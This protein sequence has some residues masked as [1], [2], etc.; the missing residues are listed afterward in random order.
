MNRRKF[1]KTVAVGAAAI[2]ALNGKAFSMNQKTVR[3]GGPVFEQFDDPTDWV[4]AHRNLG[5]TAAYC[6][7]S[8]DDSNERRQAFAAAAKQANLII[9][10]VGAW[11]NPISPNAQEAKAALEKNI[12]QLELAEEIGANC[13]VNIAGS[14]GPKWDGPHPDNVSDDT[15][16][17]I[18]ETVRKII[19]A[20]KP[21][22][23]FYTLEAMPWVLPDS[24][25][26]Y[27]EL[28]K[29]IDRKVFAVHLDPVNMINS[30][31]RYYDTGAF[32]R[33]CFKTLGPWIK[34]CHAKDIHLS[35]ELTTHLSEVIP[36]QGGLDYAIFLQEMTKLSS[37]VALMIEHLKTPAMYRQ[38]AQHIRATGRDIG[39]QVGTAA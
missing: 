15:F 36:G 38:A 35:D 32:I 4:Q 7:V 17:L 18:V 11:S 34:N 28:I 23:T 6:P 9:S 31:R 25:E 3:L 13:C 30:P 12:Q 10:E 29:A 2:T 20:V 1:G 14:R 19:D 24:P 16:D 33:H 8:F 22:R 26:V 39:I 5:Y 21:T 37:D 27:F